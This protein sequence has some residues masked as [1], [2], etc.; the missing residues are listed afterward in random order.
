MEPVSLAAV[1]ASSHFM[2]V[3][4]GHDTE[5]HTVEVKVSSNGTIIIN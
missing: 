1:P 3:S 4:N 5:N 2:H